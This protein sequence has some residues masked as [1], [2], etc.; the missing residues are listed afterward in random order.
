MAK[1]SAKSPCELSDLVRVLHH[2]RRGKPVSDS[3]FVLMRANGLVAGS[4]DAPV[5]S[6]KGRLLLSAQAKSTAGPKGPAGVAPVHIPD[7][8]ER[9]ANP[10]KGEASL[11]AGHD[12][13]AARKFQQDL[14]RAG[15]RQRTTQSWSYA[16]LVLKPGK[17][18]SAG[19]RSEPVAMLDARARVQA[20]CVAT[21]PELSGLLIDICLYDKSLA[22]AEQERGWPARSGKLAVALGLKALARHYGLDQIAEGTAKPVRPGA[23]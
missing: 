10:R 3:M 6:G 23:C 14:E 17:H 7:V 21:G 19:Q 15:L 16:S 13:A 18:S 11:L 20:A 5:L 8:L 22:I 12:I 9:L 4:A 2:L 1:A